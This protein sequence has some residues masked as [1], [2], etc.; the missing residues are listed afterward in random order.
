MINLAVQSS[1]PF[2]NIYCRLCGIGFSST[3]WTYHS[4]L[5]Y[6]LMASLLAVAIV[7]KKHKDQ[8]K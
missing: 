3:A 5:K 2:K 8:Y 1:H 7:S 4:Q 6:S